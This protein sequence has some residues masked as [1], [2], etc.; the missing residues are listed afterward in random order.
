MTYESGTFRS[1]GGGVPPYVALTGTCGPIGYGFQSVLSST[2]YF[3]IFCLKQ[4]IAT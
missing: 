4:S 1:G 2:G 3:I